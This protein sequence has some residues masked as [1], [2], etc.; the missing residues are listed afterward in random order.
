MPGENCC[1]GG[2]DQSCTV[3]RGAKYKAEGYSL[4]QVPCE[5]QGNEN[6]NQWRSHFIAAV[7]R[8][9]EV[10]AVLRERIKKNN[11]YVCSKHFLPDDYNTFV[12]EKMTK[13]KLKFGVVPHVNMPTKS[14]ETTQTTREPPK[15]R[16][17]VSPV[18]RECYSS[19]KDLCSRL[20]LKTLE[21]WKIEEEA[22][23]VTILKP[24]ADYVLPEYLIHIDIA[25][26]YLVEVW[27]WRLPEKS[28][29]YT[30]NNRSMKNITISNLV[31]MLQSH[32][33]CLGTDEKYV[34]EKSVLRHNIAFSSRLSRQMKLPFNEKTY[35]R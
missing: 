20:G 14:I 8:T 29:L 22:D 9:R 25:L 33:L 16:E 4:F 18:E 17:I 32:T 3:N 26:D 15:E 27:G 2:G 35:F 21:S 19:L 34:A 1:V 30:Q 23:H 6:Q 28:L 7:T 5:I 11:L 31:N 12:G 10:D 13:R 24:T